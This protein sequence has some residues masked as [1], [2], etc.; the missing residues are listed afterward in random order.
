MHGAKNV[1]KAWKG[2]YINQYLPDNSCQN[3]RVVILL[4]DRPISITETAIGYVITE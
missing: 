3:N 4:L 1:Q 2:E